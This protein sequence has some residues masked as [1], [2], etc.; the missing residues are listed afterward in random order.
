MPNSYQSTRW[1]VR[2][3]FASVLCAGCSAEVE[4]QPEATVRDY[5]DVALAIAASTMNGSAGGAAE[6]LYDAAKLAT[7]APCGEI[8]ARDADSFHGT[9]AGL[10]YEY[11]VHCTDGDGA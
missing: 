6:T 9:R 8:Y 5:D 3:A 4:P 2:A 1:L 11:T 7:G 10:Q